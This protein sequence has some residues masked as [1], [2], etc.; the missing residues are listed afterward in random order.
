MQSMK[1]K[2]AKITAAIALMVVLGLAIVKYTEAYENSSEWLTVTVHNK[3]TRTISDDDGVSTTTYIVFA[4]GEE[5]N[6]R[7]RG[8][9]SAKPIYSGLR[10]DHKYE[11]LVAGLG[12]LNRD[13]LE[14]RREIVDLSPERD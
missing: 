3:E 2:V 8:W 6:C 10:V 12:Y 14:N 13:I 4:G 7:G 1:T 5:F 11:I 9:S